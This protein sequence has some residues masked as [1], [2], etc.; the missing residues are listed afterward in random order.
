[1]NSLIIVSTHR[2]ILPFLTQRGVSAD[3]TKEWFPD[4]SKDTHMKITGLGVPSTLLQLGQVVQTMKPDHILQVGFAGSYNPKFPIGD[5]VEV[6]RDCF[7]DL[8]IDN[9]G[10]FIPIHKAMPDV[11]GAYSWLDYLAVTQLPHVVGV[12]VNTGSGSSE[13]IA[14][15]K[16]MWNPDVET[17]EG[18]AAML[19]SLKNNIPFTQIRVISNFVEPRNTDS[20]D[21]DLAADNLSVWLTNY[22]NS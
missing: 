1:M 15:M 18:A 3:T 5:L 19:F 17:M 22:L 10:S 4:I 16:Q 9:R 13:R 12:T 6:N 2:E 8:G 11:Q 21:M 20:W 14:A 7:A